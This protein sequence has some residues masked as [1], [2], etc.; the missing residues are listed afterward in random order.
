MVK[1]DKRL[2]VGTD[3]QKEEEERTEAN[4]GRIVKRVQCRACKPHAFTHV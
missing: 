1:N 3:L 4:M 2:E